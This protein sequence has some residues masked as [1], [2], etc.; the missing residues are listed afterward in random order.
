MNIIDE[1]IRYLENLCGFAKGTLKQH[2]RICTLWAEF[3]TSTRDKKLFT[4]EPID[5][6]DY[7]K[8]RQKSGKQR[9]VFFNN[10]MLEMLTHFGF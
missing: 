2:L 10:K 8:F 6:L 4:A 9:Q 7:I 1:Y 5:L 3:L